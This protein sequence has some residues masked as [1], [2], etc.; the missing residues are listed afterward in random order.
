MTEGSDM[1]N[2]MYEW[3]HDRFMGIPQNNTM[4]ET[5][6]TARQ[7]YAESFMDDESMK[8]FMGGT[9]RFYTDDGEAD[10]PTKP[11]VDPGFD[12]EDD[13]DAVVEDLD[14]ADAGK[15]E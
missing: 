10:Q 13:D 9:Q 2:D 12:E 6:K 14:A 15:V 7:I 11:K 3:G 8:G 1:L 4:I 5:R